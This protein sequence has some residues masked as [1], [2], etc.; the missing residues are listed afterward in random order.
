M[1]NKIGRREKRRREEGQKGR[2]T[3]LAAEVR[4]T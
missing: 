4:P 1:G 3:S 2:R